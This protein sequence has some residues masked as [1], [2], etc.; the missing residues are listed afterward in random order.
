MSAAGLK[1]IISLITNQMPY[2]WLFLVQIFIPD[3]PQKEIEQADKI[4]KKS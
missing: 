3:T 1:L 4:A 2:Y